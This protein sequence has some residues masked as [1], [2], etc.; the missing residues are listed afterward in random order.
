MAEKIPMLALS[1]TMSEGHIAKWNVKEGDKVSSGDILLEVE[2]DKA[3]MDYEGTYDGVVLK[4]LKG[5]GSEAAVGE[6]IAIIGEEGE[7]I[8]GL[9]EEVAADLPVKK[10]PVDKDETTVEADPVDE[11]EEKP[12]PATKVDEKDAAS[13]REDEKDG[14]VRSSPLA[15]KIAKQHDLDLGLVTGS[16]P[17][18]RIVK[19]D[20]EKAIADGVKP[21]ATKAAV[22]SLIKT[23]EEVEIPHSKVRRIVAE[24]L[25]ESKYTAPHYYLKLSVE[26]DDLMQARSLL[27]KTA[28][29]KVS[30]NAFLIK[31]ITETLKRHRRVNSTWYED[32]IVEH[33]NIDI[34]LAVAQ[35]DGL[36]TPVVR[37]CEQ[38]GIKEIESDLAVLIEKAREGKL[39]PEEYTGATFTIS[40]LGSYGIEEF[41]AIINPPGSAILAVGAIK[42]EPVVRDD[43]TIEIRQTMKLTLSCDHRTIDGAVGAEFLKDL[44]DTIES[45]IRALF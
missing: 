20:V 44:K 9:L 12:E 40:S 2:T 32:K 41:T 34:G 43:D 7:D 4:I 42:K 25:A 24:R 1:P 39:Q 15:R 29:Q 31:L 33:G 45:P 8:S 35:P 30:V 26:M 5:E 37:N 38:K 19:A 11:P 22:A 13:G 18:G 6:P 23:T 36:I 27:N 10:A 14:V 3:T 16:G 21:T 17:S 28:D